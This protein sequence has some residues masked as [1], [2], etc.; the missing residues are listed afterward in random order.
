MLEV[1]EVHLQNLMSQGYMTTTELATCRVP[2][3]PASPA[4]VGDTSWRAWRSTG[5][6]LVCH[7]INFF[8]PYCGPMAWSCIT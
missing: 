3:D 8:V 4:P 1:M 6:D 2:R 5:G 7:H